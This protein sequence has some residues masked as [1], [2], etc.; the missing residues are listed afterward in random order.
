MN[1]IGAVERQ[2]RAELRT[3]PEPARKSALAAAVLVLARRLDAEPGDAVA[4]MLVRELRQAMAYLHRRP[5]EDLSGDVERFLASIAT[6]DGGN[7]AY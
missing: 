1:K 2:A 3:L 6:T 4:S 7:P 5:T